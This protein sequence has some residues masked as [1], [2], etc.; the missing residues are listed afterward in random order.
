MPSGNCRA[1]VAMLKRRAPKA[2]TL[3]RNR[4]VRCDVTRT[5][6]PCSNCSRASAMCCVDSARKRR[7]EQRPSEHSLPPANLHTFRIDLPDTS[8]AI[9]DETIDT[10]ATDLEPVTPDNILTNATQIHFPEPGE[11]DVSDVHPSLDEDQLPPYIT[12]LPED[13]DH[14]IL[15]LLRRRGALMLP[16]QGMI[17]ELLR[18]FVCYMYPML[19][20][21]D[22]GSFLGSIDG[23]SRDTISLVLFQAVLFAGSTFADVGHLQNEGFQSHKDARKTFFD[24]VK[25]LYEMDVES[26]PTT[27]VQVL[28]LMTFWYGR[29]NDT[30]GRFY[31]LRIAL[32]LATDIGLDNEHHLSDL[33]ERQRLGRNLWYCC[34]VRDK[35]LSVTERRQNAHEGNSLVFPGPSTDDL[36]A[37]LAPALYKYYMPGCDLEVQSLGQLFAQKVKLCLIIGRILDS[38]YELCGVRRID[39]SETFMVLIPKLEAAH[40]EAV[41]RDQ[42]L[43]DWYAETFSIRAAAFGRDHRCNGPVLG[44]HSATLELLYYTA[45]CTVHRPLLLQPQ[46]EDSA[47]GALKNFARLTLR[48]AARRISEIGRHLHEGLLIHRLSPVGVGA[49]IAASIQH[50]KDALSTDAELRATGRLYLSQTLQALAELRKRYNSA[51][52]AMNFIER[53]RSGGLPYQSFEWED[54]AQSERL[55]HGNVANTSQAQPES[56]STVGTSTGNISSLHTMQTVMQRNNGRS[57][58][59]IVDIF[60]ANVGDSMLYPTESNIEAISEVLMSAPFD[61]SDIDWASMDLSYAEAMAI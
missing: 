42:E 57:V 55:R 44:V 49:F 51:D 1:A 26:N 19:P 47:A 8:D 7:L 29:Q 21:L 23:T 30:K 28:L 6:T 16:S 46:P 56:G 31:W 2:C 36:T 4:K 50:L 12:P 22:L 15:Q 34:L 35:L 52:C 9:N 13:L 37:G 10:G 40:S 41:V 38:Q 20:L 59:N 58:N 48:S 18:S 43:R 14:D 33:P 45:L 32:S 39:S 17:Q 61:A 60:S 11:G 3:C 27:M 24:R 25:L 54:R 5:G 53:V